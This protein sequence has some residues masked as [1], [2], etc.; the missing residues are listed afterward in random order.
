M[1]NTG[2][3][4]FS[5]LDL[6]ATFLL[7]SAYFLLGVAGL[8][9]AIAPG[10]ATAIFPAV[11]IA[12]ASVL[13]GGNQRLIGVW[14]GSFCLNLWVAT[15]HNDLNYRSLLIAAIIALGSTFQVFIASSLV[16]HRLQSAWCTLDTDKAIIEL[17]FIAGPL[18]CLIAST[19]ANITLVIFSVIAVNELWFN[20]WNWWIGD[21]IGVLLFAPLSLM[22]LL[23]HQALWRSR[24]KTVAI[25]TLVLTA[26]I[27]VAFVYVSDTESRRLKQQIAE[28]GGVFS[29]QLRA[30]LRTYEEI[31]TSLNNLIHTYP[32]I[33]FSE[34]EKFTSQSFSDH[35]DL[36]ALSWNPIITNQVRPQFEANLAKEFQADGLT[37]TQL[38]ASG[39]LVPA[40]QRQQYVVIQYIAPLA[41]NRNA[42][43][44]D[45]ASDIVRNEAIK[46]AMLTGKSAA[47]SPIRLVQEQGYSAG[48]LLLHPVYLQQKINKLTDGAEMPMPFGFAVGVFR[49]E[50]ML[51][52]LFAKGLVKDLGLSIEDTGMDSLNT[53]YLYRSAPAFQPQ[54]DLFSWQ[55]TLD[56]NGRLWRIMV[57]PTPEYLAV[58]RSLLAWLV[59]AAGLVFSSLQQAFL[60]A[61][62]GRTSLVQRQVQQQTETLRKESEKNLVF[63]RN[64]S[65]GIH[66]LDINGNII[67]ASD[68]FCKMLGYRRDEVIGMNVTQWDAFFSPDELPK[69]VEL[70]Y[71][72]NSRVQFETRHLRKDGSIFDVEVSGFPI[73]QEGTPILFFSSR[74]ITERKRVEN[75]LKIAATAFESQEG[76]IVTDT[77]HI[78]LRVNRAFTII[79]GYA[80]EE[81]I[82]KSYLLLSSNR[83]RAEFYQSIWKNILD[84]GF[85]EGEIWEQRKDGEN[86][87]QHVNITAVKDGNEKIIN[88]V[89]T[90]IDISLTKEAAKKIEQLAFYDRL[91]GLANRSL[92]LDRF[93]QALVAS[94][95]SHQEGAL[96]FINLDNFKALNDTLG[97]DF[98]D[99]LLK[100]VAERLSGCV[101]EADTV[102]R[103]GG[104]E[105]VI[106]L[107][108]L[109]E[110]TFEAA[111]LAENVGKKIL[112]ALNEEYILCDHKYR[113][114]P[115]IGITLF[116]EYKCKQNAD[117]LLK[118]ADIA[119]YQAKNSGR[120]ALCFFDPQMQININKRVN[121]EKQLRDA[122][123]LQQ[124]QLYY[125]IQQHSSGRVLGAE[126]LIRWQYPDD[127][128]ENPEKFIPIAEESG[129]ILP[130]GQWVLQSACKQLQLWQKNPLTQ[131][132]IL[133]INVSAKQFLQP[134][135]ITLIQNVIQEYSVNPELLKLELTES[136]LLA[137]LDENINIMNGLKDLGIKISLDDFGTGYSCL[138]YLKK[139]PLTQLK[140]DQSFVRDIVV[141]PSDQA[142]VRTIIA[143]AQSLE[144][145]TIAEGV[146]TEEQR[147]ILI[148]YGCSNYQGYLFGKP[149]PV[150]E[151]EALLQQIH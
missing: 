105:F 61:M 79:T 3:N 14:I 110:Q 89:V 117:E 16:K 1:P 7:A 59:L 34:F 120:N 130:I 77:N 135:F 58:N 78:I 106:M 63:L 138:Q 52:Q 22:V 75:E 127:I 86:Y 114:T 149:M 45:I 60:L 18:T 64:A 83:H 104:D 71:I 99:L 31:T 112:I 12:F 21:T 25:P 39:K 108:N 36:L 141:D 85:W 67:E 131:S 13:Y 65:D 68:S 20:W 24:F 29:S 145:D 118:Q 97:H 123:E 126:A 51:Q 122:L 27:I 115:S 102:A 84:V 113:S 137:G 9:L 121:L 46:T 69:K 81:V 5:K 50:E 150:K 11:G 76:I 128:L 107:E 103:L 143:M 55:D 119:M 146:E 40:E 32:L 43:G 125:Q 15:N 44:Y 48:I 92:L 66:I 26:L 10:Y 88:Y 90:F 72:K 56:F 8:Q 96:L 23:R 100:R 93:Q 2:L 38:N 109:G 142:I 70:P 17:L 116:N 33:Q 136:V 139:L 54:D 151:F 95:R 6:L 53:R 82:G 132:L 49:V 124:F 80:A 87:P 147:Q 4:R 98:G 129:L 41:K 35:P 101:R 91:T 57:Y 73:N 140:I 47:T 133:S 37:I 42:L 62:T 94:A 30:K 134:N 28:Q 19:W 144:L 148:N 111:T 74:D